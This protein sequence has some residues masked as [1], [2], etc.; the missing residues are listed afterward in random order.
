VRL[1]DVPNMNSI[2]YLANGKQGVAIV[3]GVGIANQEALA[4]SS[5]TPEAQLPFTRSSAICVFELP[6]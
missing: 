2:T 6:Q 1:S 5:L 4:H 3:V